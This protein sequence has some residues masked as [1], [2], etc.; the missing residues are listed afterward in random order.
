MPGRRVVLLILPVL[1]VLAVVVPR[2]VGAAAG[3]RSDPTANVWSPSRLKI[4][5]RCAT[6]HGVILNS[7]KMDDGDYHIEMRLDSGEEILLEIVPADQPGC[8]AGEKVNSGVCTGAH[9]PTPKSGS[10]VTVTGPKVRDSANGYIEIHPV[11]RITS[12]QG[13]RRR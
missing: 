6:V 7:S 3:C 13:S 1:A 4:L 8:K 5:S 11:W 9:I 10:D 2:H 12:G